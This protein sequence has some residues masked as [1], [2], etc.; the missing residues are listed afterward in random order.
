M[1]KLRVDKIA[2]PIIKD[3]F[4]GSVYFDGTGDYLSMSDSTDFDLGISN[5]PFTWELWFYKTAAAGTHCELGVLRG[6]G[7]AGW[8]ATN[9]HQYR[10]FQY[11]DNK[12]Y[13]QW[14]NGSANK[15]IISS[16]TPAINTWHHFAVSYDGTTTRAFLN[17]VIFGTSTEAYAKPSASNITR[18]GQD[19]SDS[20]TTHG[21][22]S[23]IRVCKGHAVYTGN[24]TPPTRE[25]EVHTGAKGVVFPAADNRTVL[26]TC[27]S[28]TDATA[29]ATGRHILTA[30]GNAHAQ[31]ANPGLFRKTNITSTI[32]ET[33]GSVYF[34]GSGDYLETKENGNDFDF[35]GDFTIE[36][37]I[38]FNT[39][40]SNNWHDFLGSSNNSAYLGSSKSGWIAAYYTLDATGLQFR[41]SYQNNNAWEFELG[42]NYTATADNWYHVVYTRESGTIYCYVNGVKLTRSSTSGT[43]GE[44][45]T[46]TSSEGFLRMGGGYGTALRQLDGYL[47][48]LRICKGHAVYTS[49]FIPPTRELEVHEGPDDDRTVFLGLYD[50]ENIFADKTGRHIIA[51]YGD[52]LSSPTPTATDS[53]IGSTT[54]TPGLTREVDPTAGPTFQGGVGFVSQNWLT[55][56][57]GTTT[58]RNRTGGRGIIA[59]NGN[60]IEFITITTTGNSQD[61]GD[62]TY[63]QGGYVT[64]LGSSTRGLIAG[65]YNPHSNTIDYITI[66]TTGNAKEFGEIGLTNGVYSMGPAGSNT[67]GLFAGGHQEP[68]SPNAIAGQQQINYVTFASL[69][70]SSDFGDLVEGVRYPAGCSSPTRAIWAGGRRSGVSPAN[71]NNIQYATIA[72][73]GNAVD[74][75]DLTYSGSGGVYAARAVSSS[76]RGVIGGGVISPAYVNS[77]DYLTIA[78]QGNSQEFGDLNATVTHAATMSNS[79]RGVFAGGYNPSA[80]NAMSFVTITSTGDAK[81][82]GDLIS[83][84]TA[85]SGMSDSHGGLS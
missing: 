74:Y 72:T 75:G 47:S 29:E 85:P 67:R 73:L 41:L 1:A 66:A 65:G 4:T 25:L 51:A 56:P 57:K 15:S 9:G 19:P 27:Q 7:T 36:T 30:A 59:N 60:A 63:T 40:N 82:F 55:L 3:E 6:G 20:V 42:W 10:G 5:E 52:R 80:T 43:V 31:S 8:N 26:L 78:T 84:A 46:I 58:D 45:A 18:I 79:K 77:I 21:Y 12:L 76:T 53:P 54:V 44:H 13:W 23:N 38:Y 64:C 49:Q 35:D 16:A 22:H 62:M 17:G 81:N 37:W 71:I 24:F 68:G 28:S 2:A 69:G 48:N 11:T 39:V 32:T 61:F 14:W 83:A 33:T 34:D 50:G 70:N